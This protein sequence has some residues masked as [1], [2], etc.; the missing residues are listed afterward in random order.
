MSRRF[1]ARYRVRLVE[2]RAGEREVI[3][4][5]LVVTPISVL[6]CRL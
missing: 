5:F 4:W 3:G 2:R 1:M 6:V